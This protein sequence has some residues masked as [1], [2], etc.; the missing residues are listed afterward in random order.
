M[1]GKSNITKRILFL[2]I[3]VA[4]VIFILFV[5]VFISQGLK[6]YSIYKAHSWIE[7]DAHFSGSEAYR[8]SES[9]RKANGRHYTIHVIR[10]KW[11]YCYE[12]NGEQHYFTVDNR[13]ESEPE[14][15]VRKIIAAEDDHSLHL[16]YGS[17][18]VLVFMLV[19]GAF[20]IASVIFAVLCISIKVSRKAKRK[21][22]D[23]E[24]YTDGT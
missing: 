7:T 16:L 9:R 19:L 6:D 15:P 23:Y 18:G 11:E 4:A 2:P 20:I 14:N 10:Y 17:G 13:Q 5:G 8:K 24:A 22:G 3:Y 12:L 21:N 1:K